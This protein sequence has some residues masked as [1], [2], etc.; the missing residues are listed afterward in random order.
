MRIAIMQPYFLP[1][2]GYFQ[3]MASVDKFI[4]LDDVN[5]I[6]RGWI[7]RNR[8]LIQGEPRWLTLPLVG[9]SQNRLIRDILIADDD[10]WRHKALRSI[11]A[12]YR[13]ASQFDQV[14]PW[15][16]KL[17]ESKTRNLS[18]FLC[19]SLTDLAKQLELSV[20]IESTSSRY[21]NGDL[22]GEARILDICRQ[23]GAAGYVNLPGGRALYHG[24]RFQQAGIDLR[25]V[26]SQF[27]NLTLQYDPA[28]GPTLSILD[29]AMR[30]P[31]SELR[32]ALDACLL[33][34]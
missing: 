27:E 25:F 14:F 33:A 16:T 10:R 23:E 24:E 26:D 3:L 15:V 13:N 7:N 28:A 30:N 4:L 29:L 6:N 34:A 9:A 21:P 31:L 20:Q 5:Y 2:L 8:I 18:Q 32:R 1:Y 11:E 22:V 19:E 12:S 17:L